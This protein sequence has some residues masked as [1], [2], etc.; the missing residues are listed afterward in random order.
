LAEIIRT[1]GLSGECIPGVNPG[2]TITEWQCSPAIA[3][4]G[5]YKGIA[6]KLLQSVSTAAFLFVFQRRVF[7]L[8]KL[9]LKLQLLRSQRKAI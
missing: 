2:P 5:L 1:E 9:V 6:P 3:K 7:E 4:P 8:V